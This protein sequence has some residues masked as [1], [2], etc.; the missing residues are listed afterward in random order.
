[1]AEY[2]AGIEE[3]EDGEREQQEGNELK[4]KEDGNREKR[5]PDDENNKEGDSEDE[6]QPLSQLRKANSVLIFAVQNAIRL[7]LFFT[8]LSC[9]TFSK[10]TLIRLADR[11]RTLTVKNLSSDSEEVSALHTRW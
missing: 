2:P 4:N 11:L 7:I 8:V 5:G 10:L 6:N 1:M 3:R 9:I